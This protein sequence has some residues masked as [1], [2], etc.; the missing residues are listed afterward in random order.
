MT[1]NKTAAR[2]KADVI[3]AAEEVQP[4]GITPTMAASYKEIYN[5]L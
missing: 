5:E 1:L 3:R 4:S 2:V